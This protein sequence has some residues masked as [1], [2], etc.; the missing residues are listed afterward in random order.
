MLMPRCTTPMPPCMAIDRAMSAPVTLSMFEETI[1]RSK[2][3]SAVS[4]ELT[5]I[6]RRVCESVFCGRKRKSSKVL[7]VQKAASSGAAAKAPSTFCHLLVVMCSPRLMLRLDS[8][9]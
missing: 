5:L 1:G 3:T 4:S 9:I 2:A 7:P 8:G 6:L